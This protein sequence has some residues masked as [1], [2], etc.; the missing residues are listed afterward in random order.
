VLRAAEAALPVQAKRFLATAVFDALALAF[1]QHAAA[2]FEASA[3]VQVGGR[4]LA[5]ARRALPLK[6]RA[7]G[8]GLADRAACVSGCAPQA[9][10]RVPLRQAECRAR[11]CESGLGSTATLRRAVP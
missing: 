9:C 6:P 2:R 10:V 1:V 8:R 11:R 7:L 5:R 4:P 3:L